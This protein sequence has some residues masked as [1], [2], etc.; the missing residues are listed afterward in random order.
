MV[1]CGVGSLDYEGTMGR[2]DDGTMGLRWGSPHANQAY[3]T[4]L[5]GRYG[6]INGERN[7]TK[8]SNANS[9]QRGGC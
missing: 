5:T 6:E 7:G 4:S 8:R 2:W 3:D 9:D 1:K